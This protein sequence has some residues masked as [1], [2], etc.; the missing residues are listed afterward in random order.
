MC[1]PFEEVN[2]IPTEALYVES[3]LGS[4]MLCEPYVVSKQQLE[5]ARLALENRKLRRE[6]DLIE[7]SREYRC[8]DEA[9]EPAAPDGP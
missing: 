3:E 8:C 9:E 2:I 4:C 6:I 1:K 7:Q 5:L